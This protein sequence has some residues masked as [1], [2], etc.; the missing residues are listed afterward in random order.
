M[1]GNQVSPVPLNDPNMTQTDDGLPFTPTLIFLG[2][3]LLLIIGL[4]VW[5]FYLNGT[6]N[7]RNL[8]LTQSPYCPDFQCING[9]K[10]VDY[11]LDPN[12][13]SDTTEYETLNYCSINA[14]PTSFVQSLELCGGILSKES[15]NAGGSMISRPTE[16]QVTD[17]AK[18]YNENYVDT[19]GW[20]WKNPPPEIL[21]L[22]DPQPDPVTIALSACANELGINNN[23]DIQS[24]QNKCGA[25][26]Q[27]TVSLLPTLLTL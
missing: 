12:G 23:S 16:K 21:S 19:C 7:T 27:D 2:F 26:C 20:S 18:F 9:T 6:L 14:P 4:T 22:T 11:K 17:F 10:K 24:L 1:S 13:D 8:D 3:F 5:I 15:V 25:G